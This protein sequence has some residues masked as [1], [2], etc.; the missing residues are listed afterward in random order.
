[1]EVRLELKQRLNRTSRGRFSIIIDGVLQDIKE[2]LKNDPVSVP[3]PRTLADILCNLRRL[4]GDL[5]ALDA[6]QLSYAQEAKLVTIPDIS[7]DEIQEQSKGDILVKV[8][9]IAQALWQ[10]H[11]LLARWHQGLPSSQAEV[12]TVAYSIC[13]FCAYLLFWFKPQDVT[14]PRI[15]VAERYPNSN[16]ILTLAQRGPSF[17]LGCYS[18]G[19][20][21]SIPGTAVHKTAASQSQT[22]RG[23][24]ERQTWTPIL[25]EIA[26]WAG[27]IFCAV[28][29]GLV[30][31]IAWNFYFPSSVEKLLW[32]VASVSTSSLPICWGISGA[33]EIARINERNERSDSKSLNFMVKFL[34]LINDYIQPPLEFSTGI[35]YIIAR[36]FLI[37]ETFRALSFLPPEVFHTTWANLFPQVAS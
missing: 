12:V 27:S 26:L 13:T 37:V 24:P 9:A 3:T 28:L 10:I 8:L 35:I 20:G 19:W 14:A 31:C 30:H 32:R 17:L 21:Y 25:H 23:G 2:K 36:L 16:E 18:G 15:I 4:D 22:T 5:W 7:E 29:F 11:Q 1:M 34:R 33:L 6:N